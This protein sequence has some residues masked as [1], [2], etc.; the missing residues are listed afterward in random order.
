MILSHAHIDHS[1]NIPNLVSKGFKGFFDPQIHKLCLSFYGRYTKHLVLIFKGSTI[2]VTL[3]FILNIIF[4]YLTEYRRYPTVTAK[5]VFLILS[6]SFTI[7]ITNVLL[8]LLLE[9]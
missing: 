6:R 3:N 8:M 9:C 2:I 1:G 4:S 5:N 7:F